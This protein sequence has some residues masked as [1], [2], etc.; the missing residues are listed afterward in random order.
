[1]KKKFLKLKPAI[2]LAIV[3]SVALFA[4]VGAVWAT[5]TIGTDVSTGGT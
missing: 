4:T 2:Q 5:T 3:T 1:M